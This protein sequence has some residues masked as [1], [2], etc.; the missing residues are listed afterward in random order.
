M[1]AVVFFK[2]K[3]KANGRFLLDVGSGGNIILTSPAARK[4]NLDRHY[5]K[6]RL[7]RTK[8]GGIGGQSESCFIDVDSI[9]IADF[10]LKKLEIKY[11]KDKSGAFASANYDGVMGNKIFER[12]D[13]IIDFR[14]KELYLQPNANFETPFVS[15][16]LGFTFAN[17]QKTFNGW[18]VSG[19]FENEPA[20][21]AGLEIG[22]TIVSVNGVSVME[23]TLA[24]QHNYIEGLNNSEIEL[25]IKS[26]NSIR[27]VTFDLR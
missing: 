18:I 7:Y 14:D 1:P 23:K 9:V 6:K 17:R 15:S 22:D 26:N 3:L 21:E 2:D 16:N 11:S 27:T 19:L 13:M 20:K 12:F 10:V 8:V 25:G 24:F 4:Y 5:E